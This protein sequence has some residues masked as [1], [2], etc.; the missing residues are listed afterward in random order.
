MENP[1]SKPVI[2]NACSCGSARAYR[3]CCRSLYARTPEEVACTPTYV[4]FVTAVQDPYSH[5]LQGIIHSVSYLR[6]YDYLYKEEEDRVDEAIWWLNK[7]LAVPACLKKNENARAICWFHPRA[8]APISIMWVI[9]AVL[10][11]HGQYVMLITSRDPG[12]VLY[13]DRWQVVAKP[14]R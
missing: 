14:R 5:S 1:V 13:R 11:E 2:Y 3:F 4:R 7:Y 8:K 12:L 10:R 9:A 6:D